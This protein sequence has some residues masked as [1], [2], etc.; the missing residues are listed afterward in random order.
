[1]TLAF[2]RAAVRPSAPAALTLLLLLLLLPQA[3]RAQTAGLS[4]HGETLKAQGASPSAFSVTGVT[5]V[6]NGVSSFNYTSQGLATGPYPG[7][8]SESGTV[9][10]QNNLTGSSRPVLSFSAAYTVNSGTTVITGT[11]TLSTPTALTPANSG[12]CQSL[13][14][15]SLTTDSVSV[16]FAAAYTANVQTPS[17]SF[18]DEG[19]SRV[20]GDSRRAYFTADPS[21]TFSQS[22]AFNE[23][24][25]NVAQITGVT[26][27]PAAATNPVGTSHTVTATA[28]NAA[29]AG[30]SGAFVYFDVTADGSPV[31]SSRS[32]T[33]ASGRAALIYQ[34]PEWPRG[35]G[36]R[37]CVDRND[38]GQ[39]DPT[40][41]CAAASKEWVFPASTRG[42]ATGGG[43]LLDFQTQRDGVVLSFN[44]KSDAG[45]AKG[46]CSVNDKAGD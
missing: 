8:Y 3:A 16:N 10:F 15:G 40:D 2:P 34:G 29:G 32:V 19:T 25:R 9:T 30:V 37:A 20:F 38:N 39:I 11:K 33:N 18:T 21:N 36:I 28:T 31:L 12:V 35:D 4:L 17:G 5:C 7:T 23:T 41:P 13:P 27:T 26:L 22:Y 24:F 44:F 42:A 1:M 6:P 45:G 46:N 14:N 43:Q